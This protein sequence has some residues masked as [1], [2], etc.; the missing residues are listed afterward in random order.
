MI[1][2]RPSSTPL[3]RPDSNGSALVGHSLGGV[4]ITET[5]WRHPERV[6]H[7]VYVGALVPG[8]GS[9][10]AIIQ[11]GADWPSGELVPIEEEIAKAGRAD[12]RPSGSWRRTPGPVR[13]PHGSGVEASRAQPAGDDP[14]KASRM[15]LDH[16]TNSA[17]RS[18]SGVHR[19]V[20]AVS[21]H[22]TRGPSHRHV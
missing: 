6:A 13:G 19:W 2:C 12:D 1:A 15:S 3:T 17:A 7:L 8:P 16:F 4:T 5:A 14:L 10:A 11:T 20:F 9:C 21:K 18:S 22:R